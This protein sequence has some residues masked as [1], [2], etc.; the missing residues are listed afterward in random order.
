MQKKKIITITGTLGSGK[1]STAKKLAEVLHYKHASSGDFMRTIASD[2]GLS[3]EELLKIAESDVSIDTSVDNL[4][5]E[6]GKDENVVIDSR[7]GFHFIPESF[8]VFLNLDPEIAAQRILQDTKV[9][10]NRN[11]EARDSFDTVENIIKS[12]SER[13]QG[14][15]KRYKE[16]YNIEDHRAHE[17][18]NLIVDTSHTSL[19]NVVEQIFSKYKEWLLM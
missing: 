11:T 3:L 8:K 4:N 14:E 9:N 1:S 5:R 2:R 12:I 16:L 19:D 17:N 6:I 15:K 13:L 7:L 18:F 10:P